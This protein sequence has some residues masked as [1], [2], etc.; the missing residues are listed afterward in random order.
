M[1][2]LL[3]LDPM[4]RLGNKFHEHVEWD[5]LTLQR[6]KRRRR[7]KVNAGKDALTGEQILSWTVAIQ[8]ESERGSGRFD[9]LIKFVPVSFLN[10]SW[11]PDA[12]VVDRALT[13]AT[14][15]GKRTPGFGPC[16]YGSKPVDSASVAEG[17]K[18]HRYQRKLSRLSLVDLRG[19]I[20]GL[21]PHLWWYRVAILFEGVLL[22]VIAA[23]WSNDPGALF[24]VTALVSLVF[25]VGSSMHAPF[26]DDAVDSLDFSTRLGNLG[27]FILGFLKVAAEGGIGETLANAI[28][29]VLSG[30]TLLETVRSFDPFK[31]AC[32]QL[33]NADKMKKA[34]ELQALDEGG[35]KNLSKVSVQNL[36][37]KTLSVLSEAQ[38]DWFSKHHGQDLSWDQLASPPL[39][40]ARSRR[41]KRLRDAL[42]YAGLKRED[43]SIPSSDGVSGMAKWP[44]W[45]Q[46]PFKEFS[47]LLSE[48]NVD[49]N[50]SP[51][52]SS[53]RVLKGASIVSLAARLGRVAFV[54]QLIEKARD[55][56]NPKELRMR[57]EIV[58]PLS[59]RTPLMEAAANG[60][61]KV[62]ELLFAAGADAKTVVKAKKAPPKQTLVR[63]ADARKTARMLSADFAPSPDLVAT[64][65][66][67]PAADR[68]AAEGPKSKRLTDFNTAPCNAFIRPLLAE[69]LVKRVKNRPESQRPKE[70]VPC[71][72]AWKEIEELQ[73]M[74]NFDNSCPPGEKVRKWKKEAKRGSE[75]LSKFKAP[76]T[77]CQIWI[78][79]DSRSEPKDLLTENT[80]VGHSFWKKRAGKWGETVENVDKT[81]G[82]EIEIP[83]RS[84]ALVGH[85]TEKGIGAMDG[86]WTKKTP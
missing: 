10:P 72:G 71:E 76:A 39:A 77:M 61:A 53:R 14:V 4:V 81:I 65:L 62:V 74:T 26:I 30:F 33:E 46:D 3:F 44:E 54:E 7:I 17:L 28:L 59:G 75:R 45:A 55:S 86:K 58:D 32:E 73:K 11:E 42:G 34:A 83:P 60:H 85:D 80:E 67:V 50:W 12:A 48:G 21:E 40:A 41:T 49:V 9:G 16:G 5:H 24:G 35:V 19:F 64:A 84:P 8:L 13:K 70:W 6:A 15:Q 36:S 2:I 82:V 69:L 18:L 20:D 38:A 29:F 52:E 66:G 25:T 31:T 22:T 47:D 57:L 68:W 1:K 79:N 27:I 56:M 78:P 23:V 43:G 37:L 51:S 63:T